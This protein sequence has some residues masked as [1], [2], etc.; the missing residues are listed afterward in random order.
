MNWLDELELDQLEDMETREGTDEQR[1]ERFKITDLSSLNWAFRKLTTL[2]KSH[3][4]EFMVAQEELTRIQ[5]WFKKQDESYQTSRQFLEG[6]IGEYA[7]QQRVIDPKWRQ[8]TPYGLVSF[9]KQQPKWDYGDEEALVDYMESNGLE[10]MV[11]TKKTPIKGELKKTL[12]VHDGKAV[13]TLTGEI[14]PEITVTDQE[15]TVT[16]KLE[17]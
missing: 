12:Y 16:I 10:N 4:E 17:G 2:G 6:L 15:E 13:N 1:K 9:R 11:Q 8:K 14:V 7:G 3:A 5:D